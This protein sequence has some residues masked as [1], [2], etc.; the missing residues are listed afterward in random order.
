MYFSPSFFDI[1]VHLVV[2]LVREIKCYGPIYMWWMCPIEQ[3]MK[4]LKGIER[5]YTVLKHILLKGT[6]QKKLLSF[7]HSTLKRQNLLGFPSL[8]MTKE[9][10]DIQVFQLNVECCWNWLH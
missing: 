8:G 6:L 1:M 9:W 5:I 7:V 10:E 2:H 3:Y 4:I